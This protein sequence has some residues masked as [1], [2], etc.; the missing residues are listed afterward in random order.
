MIGTFQHSPCRVLLPLIT[1][2]NYYCSTKPLWWISP[3]TVPR[4]EWKDRQLLSHSW[5]SS[6]KVTSSLF[7]VF[8]GY[9][10]VLLRKGNFCE[11]NCVDFSCCV[12][13]NILSPA[14]SN[15][16]VIK[17]ALEMQLWWGKSGKQITGR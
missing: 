4:A 14:V 2:S 16:Q 10:E 15:F 6:S 8:V 1:I 9:F 11:E 12:N 3:C 5:N 7:S 13:E 17:E